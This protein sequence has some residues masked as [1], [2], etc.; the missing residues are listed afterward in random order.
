MPSLLH[1]FAAWLMRKTMP[2]V[3]TGGQWSGT[4]YVDAF[5]RTREPQPNE[6]LAE[7]KGVAW[8]CI[9]INAAVCANFPP[10]LYVTTGKGQAQPKCATRPLPARVEHR[11]RATPFLAA[12]TKA[13]AA[14]EEVT[15]HPLLTLL[16]QVNPVHNAF[17]L[18]ELTQ[19]YLEVHGRAFWYLEK[20]ALG[21]PT[22]IWILPT[23]NVTPKRG[24]DSPRPIDYYQ[25]RTG[26]REQRFAPDEV[27][28]FRFPDP[29]DPYTGG[30]S[31]LRAAFE[32]VGFLSTYTS[33]K[34]STYEN[35]ALPAALVSPDQ[36]IGEEERDRLETQINQRFRRGGAGRIMVA[37][38]GMRLNVLSH[39]MGDLAAL[40]DARATKEDVVN[41]FHVPIAFLTAQTNL[42]NLQASQAL[43][44]QIAIDPRLQRR[45]EKLNEQLVPLFDPTGRLFL[46]SEDP[47]PV[48]QAAGILQQQ[49]DLKYGVVSINEIRGERG[50]PPVPWGNVPWL[51]AAMLPTDAPNRGTGGQIPLG[52]NQETEPDR[53]G[54]PEIA[55]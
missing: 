34:N 46:A 23:Q 35:S 11:L 13:A 54:D 25:V 50:L 12:R 1:R 43:H 3:L 42:A 32:Q 30:L 19:T 52:H 21:V 22:A 44:M 39:S 55:E 6:L 41:A 7:L 15:D 38:S 4:S 26:A 33:F 37:E 5:K 49:T 16:A 20:D 10:R 36:V 18:W 8:A 51:P 2:P 28:F 9:S 29:R 53:T 14:I 31:P 47:V 45:D 27:I 17:D 48:D 24:P 40:A